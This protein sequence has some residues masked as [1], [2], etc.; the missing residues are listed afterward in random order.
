MESSQNIFGNINRDLVKWKNKQ[1]ILPL[2][3]VIY[4][5]RFT[6]QMYRRMHI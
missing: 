5:T 3:Y 2:S 6:E 4:I 1:K